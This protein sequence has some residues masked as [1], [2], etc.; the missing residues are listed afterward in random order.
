MLTNLPNLAKNHR[1]ET[2]C[3][4]QPV[5]R[6][7]DPSIFSYFSKYCTR[8]LLWHFQ[9]RFITI[10]KLNRKTNQLK[11]IERKKFGKFLSVTFIRCFNYLNITGTLKLISSYWIQFHCD[12]FKTKYVTYIWVNEGFQNPINSEPI[13]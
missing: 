12:M 8:T 10:I 3:F 6:M 4:L 13:F 2:T 5:N 1:K 7:S 9:N 11:N